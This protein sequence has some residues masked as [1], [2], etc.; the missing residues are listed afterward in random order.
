[1]ALVSELV[2]SA[3]LLHDDVVDEGME[4]R[5]DADLS[6]GLGQRDQRARW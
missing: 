2:H 1:M 6:L 4:R 5:G 3:T